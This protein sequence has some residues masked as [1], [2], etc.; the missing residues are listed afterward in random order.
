[1][2]ECKKGAHSDAA[3]SERAMETGAASRQATTS[4]SEFTTP[5]P[6]GQAVHIADFLNIGA[7][8][9]I[10]LRDLVAITGWSEREVRRRI[11][12]ERRAGALIVSDNKSG[13]YLTDDPA[14]AQRFARSMRHRA[15]EIMRTARAIERGAGLD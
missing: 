5:A 7:A 11:E 3:A 1:M 15:G 6:P 12:A 9:A 13:Y 2:M 8:H 10:P 4:T 14:E